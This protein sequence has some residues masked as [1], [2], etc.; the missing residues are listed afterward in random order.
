L[1]IGFPRGNSEVTR[2]TP[3]GGCRTAGKAQGGK[4]R[5]RPARL[6]DYA[7]A[8]SLYLEG[9]ER[10]LSK[11]GQ[12]NRPRILLKFRQGYK[13]APAKI[14][15]A[16]DKPIG[17][18]QVANFV[19][20]MHLRQL[21]LIREFRGQGIGTRLVKE[22]LQC[23]DKLGKPVTLDVM[24]GNPARFLYLRLGFRQKSQNAATR[25]MIWRPPRGE[26]F[27]PRLSGS[28]TL[29]DCERSHRSH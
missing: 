29:N 1:R 7:F 13:L 18:I 8:L 12:W 17:W 27:T 10:H 6:G 28:E 26:A 22:L 19:D 24:H 15:C 14:I 9:A 4:V 23:A 2:K 25:Q 3:L 21:H 16:G 20:H 11:I 5:L